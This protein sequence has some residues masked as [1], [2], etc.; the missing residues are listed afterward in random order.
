ML[1]MYVTITRLRAVDCTS[2]FFQNRTN[3]PQSSSMGPPIL[4]KR[5]KQK[6]CSEFYRL[7][8]KNFGPNGLFNKT[9][10][11]S[12]KQFKRVT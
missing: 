6:I 7:E 2:K 12:V 8:K 10:K 4:N 9:K 5:S 11:T 3:H 1:V